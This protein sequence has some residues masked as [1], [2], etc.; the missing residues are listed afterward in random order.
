VLAGTSYVTSSGALTS[1]TMTNQGAVSQTLSTTSTQYTVPQGYH[2]GSG[3]VKIVTETKS[4][5]PST[6]AQTIVATSG[7]V[8]SSV[9]VAAIPTKYKDTTG[10][11]AVA[12]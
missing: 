12:S 8:I 11:D 2:N 1:G 7:K 4:A 5:T 3:T 9:S 10:A 6:S